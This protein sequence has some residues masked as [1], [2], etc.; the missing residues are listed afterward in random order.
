MNCQYAFESKTIN[1]KGTHFSVVLMNILSNFVP[2]NLLKFNY[3]HL[4]WMNSKMKLAKITKLF[5]KNPSDSLKELLMTQS[6]KCSNLFFPAKKKII[7]KRW[8]KNWVI[9]L[10]P[11]KH[12]GHYLIENNR[13]VPNITPLIVNGFVVSDFTTKANLFNNFFP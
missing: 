3:K 1:E 7:T 2:H 8:L 13:K 5:Y 4:P 12:T 9:L 10:Q 11:K 6:T